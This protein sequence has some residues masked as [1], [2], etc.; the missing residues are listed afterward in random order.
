M[1]PVFRLHTVSGAVVAM[2]GRRC[3]RGLPDNRAAYSHWMAR[4]SPSWSACRLADAVTGRYCRRVGWDETACQLREARSDDLAGVAGLCRDS[5][6]WPW[7]AGMIARE[8]V[9]T[10]VVA[11]VGGDLAGVAKTHHHPEADEAAPEG[12]YLGG[13]VV[14]RRWRRLGIGTMLTTA[15]LDWIWERSDMAFYFANEH[16]AA[17][18][19]LHRTLGFAPI[20]TAT[21]FHGV[22]A[23]GQSRLILFSATRR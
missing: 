3:R 7:T 13:I 20:A 16:N 8:P 15:R 22:A 21:T 2:R 10:V 4:R 9:R 11:T 5:G 19:E 14:G 23:H 6:G 18:I 17:S 1:A 12:H